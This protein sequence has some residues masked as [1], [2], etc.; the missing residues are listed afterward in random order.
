MGKMIIKRDFS[1]ISPSAKWLL[2][3]KGLDEI[4]KFNEQQ[5][6]ESNSF[7]SFNEA[8]MFFNDMVFVKKPK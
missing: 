3:M 7:E 2:L 5:N 6:I 1:S 4:K 8:K